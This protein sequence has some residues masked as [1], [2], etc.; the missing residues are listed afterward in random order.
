MNTIDRKV[1]ELTTRFGR[2][3]AA[4]QAAYHMGRAQGALRRWWEQVLMSLQQSSESS[5]AA[6]RMS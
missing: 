6:T 2:D 5:S 1:L 3:M 4:T